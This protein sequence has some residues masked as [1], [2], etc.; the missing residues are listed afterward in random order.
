MLKIFNN[1]NITL[2]YRL[3]GRAHTIKS[4]GDFSNSHI[5]LKIVSTVE[6]DKSL[7]AVKIIPNEM[8]EAVKLEL[9]ADYIFSTD[10]KIFANGFQSWTDSREFCLNEKIRKPGLF[11]RGVMKKYIIDRYGD[12]HFYKLSGRKGVFHSHTYTYFRNGSE[13]KLIGS[14]SEKNGYTIIESD[15]SKKRIR[16]IKDC[17]GVLWNTESTPLEITA[18]AGDEKT[19]FDRYFS[20]CGIKPSQSKPLT[21]WTSWYN[22]YQNIT[23]DI[24][25]GN[26]AAVKKHMPEFSV[27]QIDDGCARA[28][29]DWLDIDSEKFPRGMEFIA[30][31]IHNNN[32]MAG[33]WLAPFAAEKS[34]RLFNEKPDWI[35]KDSN[36]RPVYAG[37]NWSTFYA[38]DFY[39]PEVRMYLQEVFNTV[40]NVWK[41]D[42]VKLDFLY[43]VSLIPQHGKSRGQV[44]SEAMEFI[45]ECAK[46]KLILGC[47]VPLGS[48]F[49]LVDYCR[50]GCDVGLDWDDKFYMKYLHRE[51]IS[52]L[53][54]VINSISRRHLNGRAFLN[55]PDVFLLREDNLQLNQNQK[56][57][58]FIINSIFGGLVFT[59][60]NFN[61]YHDEQFKILNQLS[62]FAVKENIEVITI[63]SY[64]YA[65]TYSEK[66]KK[67]RFAVNLSAEPV[68]FEDVILEP[69]QTKFMKI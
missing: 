48:V 47:G 53:N 61:L 55:D 25:L 6:R 15:V 62:G 14:L 9:C 27:F 67:F 24:I 5:S 51:R 64:L 1:V 49:G 34:S 30:S 35:L 4:D 42:L 65:I 21:G 45:R 22:Y 44:M 33:I 31:E 59:S 12:G 20:M 8:I 38:L 69:Y 32:M 57:T 50:I 10:D 17:E 3:N 46:D 54:A 37:G 60:D 7:I 39:N 68:K 28:V 16:I 40:F 2:T 29:G 19:V 23:E 43:A 66:N 13:Y 18:L 36:G 26:I 52:T 58:L 63:N 56:E 41:Y 11:A